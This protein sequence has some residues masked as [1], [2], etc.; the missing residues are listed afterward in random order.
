MKDKRYDRFLEP[1]RKQIIFF[2][3]GILKEMAQ[4]ARA[5]EAEAK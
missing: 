1:I 4:K 3:D 5:Y 2:G